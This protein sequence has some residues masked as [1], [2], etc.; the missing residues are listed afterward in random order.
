MI[1]TVALLNVLLLAPLAKPQN[2]DAVT[3]SIAGQLV[4]I[5]FPI[6]DQ[7]ILGNDR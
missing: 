4:S 6:N 2:M 3:N 7:D 5:P 1:T